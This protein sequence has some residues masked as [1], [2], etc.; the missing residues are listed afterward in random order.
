MLSLPLRSVLLAVLGLFTAVAQ[1]QTLP[2]PDNLID[3]RSH[4]GEDCCGK[5]MLTRPSYRLASFRH[6]GKSGVLRSGQ[7]RHGSKCDA[8]SGAFGTRI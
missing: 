4:Q 8:A 7:H 5:A 2:L 1:A 3:L 6:T